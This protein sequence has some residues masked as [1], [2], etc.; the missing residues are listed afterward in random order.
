MTCLYVTLISRMSSQGLRLFFAVVL[1]TGALVRKCVY[2]V[3]QS[4][5]L[6]GLDY[7]LGAL[8]GMARGGVIVL[9][10]IAL[11]DS[12]GLSSDMWWKESVMI[13]KFSV[14]VD[15]APNYMPEFL[16]KIVNSIRAGDIVI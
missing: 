7:V 14:W 8:F 12:L 5:G 3:I 10:L 16:L 4:I 13:Q 1:I 15:V 9:L 2:W 6:S 11:L